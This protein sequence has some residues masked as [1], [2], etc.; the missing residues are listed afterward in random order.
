MPYAATWRYQK[1]P[2]VVAEVGPRHGFSGCSRESGLE[3]VGLSLGHTGLDFVFLARLFEIF[4]I[5]LSLLGN[6]ISDVCF[7]P[8]PFVPESSLPTHPIYGIILARKGLRPPKLR[9]FENP[10]FCLP[11]LTVY[12]V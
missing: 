1:R 10:M 9:D 6:A 7:P 5:Y 3:W 4:Q 11:S 2:R 8:F 12:D